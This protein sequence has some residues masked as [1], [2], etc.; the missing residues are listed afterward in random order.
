MDRAFGIE[1]NKWVVKTKI[2]YME[3]IMKFFKPVLLF[4]VVL[5]L[6]L[7]FMIA[8]GDDDDDDDG[9]DDDDDD[10]DSSGNSNLDS[11]DCSEACDAVFECGG[12]FW[13]EDMDECNYWCNEWRETSFDCAACFVNCWVENETCLASGEC[14]V[15]CSL[16]ACLTDLEELENYVY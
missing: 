9:D 8:C 5:C 10:D 4:L 16:G 13:Y 14:M 15:M 12:N 3:S 6:G 11:G 1:K 7:S 2:N